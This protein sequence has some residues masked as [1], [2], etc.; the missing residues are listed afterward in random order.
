VKIA[1]VSCILHLIY[2]VAASQKEHTFCD[3]LKLKKGKH[4]IC[5][6]TKFETLIVNI[7]CHDKMHMFAKFGH[8][9]TH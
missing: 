4:V 3:I 7:I 2:V 6:K 8:I 9:I 5:V 1:V